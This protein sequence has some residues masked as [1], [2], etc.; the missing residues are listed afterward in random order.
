VKSIC[1]ACRRRRRIIRELTAMLA[2]SMFASGLLFGVML[3]A[4][5]LRIVR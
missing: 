3:T 5:L 2:G 4:A 1:P